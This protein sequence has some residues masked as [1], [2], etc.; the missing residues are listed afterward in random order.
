G[1]TMYFHST[2]PGGCGGAA[3]LYMAHRD[4]ITDNHAWGTPVNLGC[5]PN[6]A[7]AENG[8]LFFNNTAAGRQELYF[9]ST[10]PPAIP[11][12]LGGSDILLSTRLDDNSAWPAGVVVNSLSSAGNDDRPAI[13]QDGLEV[14]F[15]SNRVGT[16]G[17]TDLWMA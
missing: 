4:D 14:I 15:S 13:R 5:P 12:G 16:T 9:S 6:T 10:G 7:R 11:G 8:P 3:D 17:N 1:Q 2:R